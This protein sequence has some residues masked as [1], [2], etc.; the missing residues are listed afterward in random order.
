[1]LL[2]VTIQGYFSHR[3]LQLQ[4]QGDGKLPTAFLDIMFKMLATYT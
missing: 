3:V 4:G 1:M 2:H